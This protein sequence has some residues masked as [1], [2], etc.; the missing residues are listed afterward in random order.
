VFTVRKDGAPINSDPK[1]PC[2]RPSLPYLRGLPNTLMLFHDYA[3]LKPARSAGNSHES[4]PPSAVA[5][6]V[7]RLSG[8][9]RRL[10]RADSCCSRKLSARAKRRLES[11]ATA[12]ARAP[13]ER[14]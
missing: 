13:I 5:A 9:R 7:S 10:A 12:V 3:V 8:Q 6:A 11:L 1:F 14:R 4:F 2:E